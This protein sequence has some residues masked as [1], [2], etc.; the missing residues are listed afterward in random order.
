MEDPKK[1]LLDEFK[2][3]VDEATILSICSD[4]NMDVVEDVS[5]VRQILVAISKDVEAEEATG[6]NPSGIA[7]SVVETEI[8]RPPS[9]NVRSSDSITTTTE[10]SLLPT[11]VSVETKIPTPELP[12]LNVNVFD[13]L[14]DEEKVDKLAQMFV[15]LKTIDVKLTLQKLKGDASLAIDELLNLQWL[16]DSGQRPKGVDGF[17][18]SGTDQVQPTKKK[19][20]RKQ[21]KA[22]AKARA[23]AQDTPT[24]ETE[25]IS[26]KNKDL[27]TLISNRLGVN[28][29][30][31]TSIF[32]RH[33]ASPGATVIEILRNYIALDL[34]VSDSQLVTEVQQMAE[35]FSWVPPE[36]LRATL[37]ICHAPNDALDII[38]ILGN[39]YEKPAYLKYD[40]SYSL[41]AAEGS[42]S[43]EPVPVPKSKTQANA[44]SQALESVATASR[45]LAQLRDQSAASAAAAFKKGRSDPLYRQVA[46]YYASRAREQTTIVRQT[47]SEAANTLVDTQ[48]KPGE[49]DLHG[50]GVIDGINIALD[51]AWKWWDGLAGEDRARKAKQHGLVI[52]TGWGKHSADGKSK[53]R[54]HVPKALLSDGWTI[55]VNTGHY[56]IT[57]R[58]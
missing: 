22:A 27:I 49:V 19:K 15:S 31:A 3:L 16:E 46:A 51:R 57:G 25:E 35:K 17:D 48:S 54:T 52:V 6:F 43:F 10:S 24:T 9:S 29:P 11:P 1:K 33:N 39:H 30:E 42:S 14:S 44:R 37:E 12:E 18:V 36:Y 20:S 21:R 47:I 53:L 26:I 45:D 8:S 28:I 56:L 38:H 13:G 4:Y 5:N 55:E 23:K 2:S 50:V 7:D 34:P 58:Q 32:Q 40:V 41:K